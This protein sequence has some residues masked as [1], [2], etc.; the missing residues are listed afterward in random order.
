MEQLMHARVNEH[1]KPK[2][3]VENQQLQ[4]KLQQQLIH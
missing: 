4:V 2:I 1:Q 3:K